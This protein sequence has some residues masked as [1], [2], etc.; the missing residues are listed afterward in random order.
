VIS[1]VLRALFL[2]QAPA[3]F[4]RFG[5]HTC[6]GNALARLQIRIAMEDLYRRIPSLTVVPGFKRTYLSLMTVTGLEGLDVH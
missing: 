5:R 1:Q 6:I 3:D 2:P 4:E